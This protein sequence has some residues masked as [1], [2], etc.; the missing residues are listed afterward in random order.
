MTPY[1]WKDYIN[2]DE[3]EEFQKLSDL[4][5]ELMVSKRQKLV[6]EIENEKNKWRKGKGDQ[7]TAKKQD[8]ESACKFEDFKFVFKRHVL[9]GSVFKP[10]FKNV[11]GCFIRAAVNNRHFIAKITGFRK[12]AP[13]KLLSE[14]PDICTMGLDLDTGLKAVDGFPLN[15]VSGS[16]ISEEEFKE[17][18]KTFGIK[19]FKDIKNKHDHVLKEFTR[20]LTEEEVM[21][22]IRIREDDNPKKKSNTQ[23]KIELITRRDEA[24]QYK[25]KEAAI[26][27]QSQLEQ[28]EDEER[29]RWKRSRLP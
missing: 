28:I 15:N 5:K 27:F 24:I 26:K 19:S 3:I 23:R 25:N 20:S 2:S 10:F 11:K 4:E 18:I 29:E 8:E 14:N 22:R 9:I 6:S 16:P 13:Y 17:F 12:I 1:N 21:I 7:V